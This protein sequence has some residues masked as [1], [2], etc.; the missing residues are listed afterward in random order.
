M[1]TWY[2]CSN[3]LCH[4]YL[5]FL[6]QYNSN[7][8][9]R[10]WSN[11]QDCLFYSNCLLTQIACLLNTG[12]EY[13]NRNIK[14]E[15]IV[16]IT[17]KANYQFRMHE[18]LLYKLVYSYTSKLLF[19]PQRSIFVIAPES[20]STS[21]TAVIKNPC[22]THDLEICDP[23]QQKGHLVGQVYYEIMSK[24]VCKISIK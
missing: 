23:V 15:C 3:V 17:R 8:F 1:K 10:R 21:K 9:S 7:S 24:T 6:A 13:W 18:M 5:H 14:Y 12:H 20:H 22:A 16:L 11:Y 4:V 2:Y 19:D